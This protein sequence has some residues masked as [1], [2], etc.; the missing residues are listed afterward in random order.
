VEKPQTFRSPLAVVVWIV[1]LLFAVGNW[2]DLA[3]QGRDHGSLVAAAIVLLAT[4]VAYVTALRPRI[5][6]DADGVTV[7]N[8]LRDHR[9]G[10]TGVTEV[11]LS[12]LLRVHCVAGQG[13]TRRKVISAWAVHYSKRRKLAAEARSRRRGR[14]GDFW[15]STPGLPASTGRGR[16]YSASAPDPGVSAAEAEA[17]RIVRVLSDYATAARAETAAGRA[18][19]PAGVNETRA[20]TATAAAGT[21]TATPLISTWDPLAVAAVVGPALILLI[22]S[23]L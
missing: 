23:L 19:G 4:G 5:I 13:G 9:V 15:R 20:A 8:P 17:E 22:V 14:S 10:W 3:V 11:D 1:W 21:G 2:I 6:A 16:P 7:R 12:E 18:A